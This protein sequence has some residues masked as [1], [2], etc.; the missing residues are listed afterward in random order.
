MK[1]IITLSILV[2]ALVSTVRAQLSI[3]PATFNVAGGY[4]APANSNFRLEWSVGESSS[5]ADYAAG[6]L[7]VTTGV[8]QPCTEKSV[9]TAHNGFAKADYVL[10]PNST[11]GPFEL[12]LFMTEG[13]KLSMK[14]L[15]ASGRLLEQR[16]ADYGC[17][18]RIE[19][20]NIARY[21]AGIYMLYV[22]Y[23]SDSGIIKDGTFKVVKIN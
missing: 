7:L 1:F 4:Y 14:L 9:G 19:K 11:A 23:T 2:F 8:L 17:C 13:G 5:I 18:N 21:P 20:F 16:E 12:N 10:Y 15:D 3:E 6:N 22:I